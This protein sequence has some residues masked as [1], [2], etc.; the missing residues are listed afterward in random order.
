MSKEDVGTN[1]AT[2]TDESPRPALE[3]GLLPC[4]FCGGAAAWSEGEQKEFGNEQAYCTNCYAVT[5][6]ALGKEEAAR[7]WN[8]RASG[9]GVNESLNFVQSVE[10]DTQQFGAESLV[11]LCD[12]HQI[13]IKRDEQAA[14]VKRPVYSEHY[15]D[16]WSIRIYESNGEY[17]ACFFHIDLWH[18][19]VRAITVAKALILAH[20]TINQRIAEGK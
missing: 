1:P 19:H 3:Q 11:N 20:A 2:A 7:W 15:A 6:P 14:K 17:E 10:Q 16:T 9:H 8:A 18:E 4:P 5:V 12:G 13:K